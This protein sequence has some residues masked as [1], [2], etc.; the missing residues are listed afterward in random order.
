MLLIVALFASYLLQH[1][2]IQ[3]VHETVISIFAGES[4]WGLFTIAWSDMFRDDCWTHNQ[5]DRGHVHPEYSQ[6]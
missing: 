4:L 5:T 1:K 6:L 3:A 2:K